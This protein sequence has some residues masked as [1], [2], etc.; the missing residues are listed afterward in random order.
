MILTKA[1]CPIPNPDSPAHRFVKVS[2]AGCVSTHSA[3][4]AR[5]PFQ[6]RTFRPASLESIHPEHP[7]PAGAWLPTAPRV[8]F[9][10]TPT[11]SV[12][13]CEVRQRLFFPTHPTSWHIFEPQSSAVSTSD[14]GRVFRRLTEPLLSSSF[15]LRR[16]SHR[17]RGREPRHQRQMLV[18]PGIRICLSRDRN[19][20][21][22]ERL[23]GL[24]ED[25]AH[26]SGRLIGANACRGS[27]EGNAFV[28]C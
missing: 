20:K 26:T 22:A 6:F 1:S 17:R 3:Q 27:V 15:L 23:V 2:H 16:R 21:A 12:F 9:F 4:H 28:Y 7:P 11:A 5:I 19:V 14:G 10:R 13:S 24:H 8:L 18:A 25:R